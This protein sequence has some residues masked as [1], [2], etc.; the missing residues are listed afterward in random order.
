MTRSKMMTFDAVPSGS[1]W[2]MTLRERFWSKVRIENPGGCW[3]WQGMKRGGYGRIRV[4]SKLVGAH[5][6]SWEIAHGPVPE[7]FNVLHNCP[8]GD[9]R[10]CVNPGHLWLGTYADNN[11]D[12]VQKGRWLPNKGEKNGRAKLTEADV[13]EIRRA[14]KTEP[15][16]QRQLAVR[17][18]VSLPTVHR[19][20]RGTQWGHIAD[21]A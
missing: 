10:D 3:I 14:W 8:L 13:R 11:R 7:G 21:D 16:T 6:L 2:V 18:K 4:G 1:R 9:R 19:T 5:N 12:A 15:I 17:F 20:I